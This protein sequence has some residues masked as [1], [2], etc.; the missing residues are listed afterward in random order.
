[1]SAYSHKKYRCKRCGHERMIGTNHYGEC[2]GHLGMNRCPGCGLKH[3]M[4]CDVFECMETPPAG[5]KIPEPW[6]IVKLGDVIK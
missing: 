2:Y 3:P 4:E 5:E 1:M 6:R